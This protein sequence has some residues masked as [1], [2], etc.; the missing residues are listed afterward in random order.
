MDSASRRVVP[1]PQAARWLIVLEL[2]V[3]LIAAGWALS[4][5][6][7]LNPMLRLRGTEYEYLTSSA[8]T[9]AQAW[10]EHGYIPMWQPYFSY[11]EPLIEWG[12]SSVLSPLVTFP[13]LIFGAING[14]KI[15]LLLHVMI[16]GVGG[17]VLG[18]VLGLGTVGRVLLGLLMIGRGN[19]AGLMSE[20]FFQLTVSQAFMPFALAAVF[21]IIRF[22]EKRYPVILM[23][24]AFALQ[25]FT[26]NV[27]YI[28]PTA[29]IAASVML[30]YAVELERDPSGRLRL[31]ADRRL[32]IRFVVAILFAVLLST[33]VL[34]PLVIQ[35]DYVVGHVPLGARQWA[36]WRR[37]LLQIFTQF[38]AGTSDR[39]TGV[40]RTPQD[41]HAYVLPAWFALAIFV[42]LP[43][44]RRLHRES[45]ENSRRFWVLA[46][47]WIVFFILWAVALNPII[48]TLSQSFLTILGRWR[49][50]ARMI[51]PAAFLIAVLA[52]VR[53][54]GL[55]QAIAR[56]RAWLSRAFAAI[57]IAASTAAAFDVIAAGWKQFGGT[58]LYQEWFIDECID[59]VQAAYPDRHLNIVHLPYTDVYTYLERHARLTLIGT[60]IYP[61]PITPTLYPS[62]MLTDTLADFAMAFDQN[63]RQWVGELGFQPIPQ[64]V[65]A[66]ET[67]PCGY[68]NPDALQYAFTIPLDSLNALADQAPHIQTLPASA[69]IPIQP[70]SRIY[71]H[72]T[73]GIRADPSQP[74]VVVA[75]EVAY[76]GWQVEI[77]GQP[78]QLESVGGLIG[79]VL[80]PNS[81][82]APQFIHFYYRPPLLIASM[83]VTILSGFAGI[84]FLLHLDQRI[85]P[86][87]R[88]RERVE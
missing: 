52:A 42:L 61:A 44:I 73:F 18:R 50:P 49:Y 75:R 41:Y 5:L 51:A 34:L 46:L 12:F 23:G 26:G 32:L 25:L 88:T 60:R 35:S 55:W 53:I 56:G 80:A 72:I 11:G 30:F 82:A 85:L 74:L 66:G 2:A 1:L 14:I 9:V 29:L 77:N 70:L 13:A 57:I 27:Y 40:M 67:Y 22:P 15:S 37:D 21:A 68:I 20:G 7:D 19:L 76:P 43:P 17:W 28:L 58:Q 33:A 65:L 79:V 8:F 16:G 10:S 86:R 84:V 71:D 36:A 4:D 48:V 6:L 83:I 62:L 63:E 87:L 69:V 78:A 38:F 47:F 39:Y 45:F 81:D 64:T 59:A 3:L 24:A 54:D 31:K